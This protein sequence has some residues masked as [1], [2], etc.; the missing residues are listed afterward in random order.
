MLIIINSMT[1]ESKY[2]S[3][4]MKKHFNKELVMTKEDNE[5]FKSSTKCWICDNYYV[6]NDVK[7]RNH[8]HITEKHRD[9]HIIMEELGKCN[10]KISVISNGLE[11]YMSFTINKKFSFID[12]F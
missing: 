11:K 7:L 3:E 6:D 8:Y 12:S 2:C 5:N 10:L 1:K 4:V 9:S